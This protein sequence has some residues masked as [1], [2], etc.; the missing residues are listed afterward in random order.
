[1]FESDDECLCKVERCVIQGFLC[2]AVGAVRSYFFWTHC[3]LIP[4]C[5]CAFAPTPVP[6]RS[7][8]SRRYCVGKLVSRTHDNARA[9]TIATFSIY[10]VSAGSRSKFKKSKSAIF[11]AH[12][13]RLIA[14]SVDTILCLDRVTMGMASA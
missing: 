2:D 1:M 10:T 9:Q 6:F 5:S 7:F 12:G 8:W 13:T 11:L 4:D 3:F 14:S